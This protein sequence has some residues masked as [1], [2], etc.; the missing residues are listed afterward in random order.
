MQ[1]YLVAWDYILWALWLFV[2]IGVLVAIGC[3]A[4]VELA[5]N[6]KP[7]KMTES[8]LAR[9]GDAISQVG[10]VLLF[11][12]NPNHSISGDAYRYNRPHWMTL[13]NWLFSDPEH[14][15][16]AHLKDVYMAWKLASET[17]SHLIVEAR[18]L[19]GREVG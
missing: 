15:R 17:P 9:L 7:K 11:N 2:G 6:R 10:N 16:K 19:F 8:R 12:G 13:A 14:C 4:L 3:L 18:Q 5:N 1:A